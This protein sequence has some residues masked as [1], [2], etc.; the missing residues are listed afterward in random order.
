VKSGGIKDHVKAYGHHSQSSVTAIVLSISLICCS[1]YNNA[2]IRGTRHG[3][4]WQ[5]STT[6]ATHSQSKAQEDQEYFLLQCLAHK[7]GHQ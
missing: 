3:S 1:D 6:I 5:T 4:G 2:A 7:Q